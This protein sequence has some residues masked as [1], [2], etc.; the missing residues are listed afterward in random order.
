[1]EK[2]KKKITKTTK[3]KPIQKK[4]IIEKQSGS[5]FIFTGD[6][7]RGYEINFQQKL[8]CE[9]FLL[10]NGR[11]NIAVVESGYRVKNKFGVVNDKMARSI[12]SENLTKPNIIAYLG[13][14][15]DTD[16][17]NEENV[18]KQHLYVINQMEDTHA[19]N[20]AIDMFYKLKAKYPAEKHEHTVRKLEELSDDTIAEI[21]GFDNAGGSETGTG[22][23]VQS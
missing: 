18:F 16:G 6:D 23:K 12:A 19:K 7:G 15:L 2:P 22:D 14:L 21:A 4:K 10:H 17:F 11:G 13:K 5:K 20:R 8:F 1:M 9:K 3:Q